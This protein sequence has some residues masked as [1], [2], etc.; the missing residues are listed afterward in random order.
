MLF[1]RYKNKKVSILGD[2]ISTLEGYNPAGSSIY[3]DAMMAKD[4]YVEKYSDTWWGML[5]EY[6]GAR[7]LINDSYSGSTM[8]AAYNILTYPAGCSLERIKNLGTEDEKPDLVIIFMG[9][10]DYYNKIPIY[11][12]NIENLRFFDNSYRFAIEMINRYYNKPEIWIL[13]IPSTINI[14]DKNYTFPESFDNT[15]LREY[16]K[17]L[18]EIAKDYNLKYIDLY[19]TGSYETL[20]G[21]HPN[22]QGMVDI[23]E[24]IRAGI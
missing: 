13:N 19:K 7:L 2:S 15:Y 8:A 17:A 20:D 14:K 5:I 4:T 9:T 11:N 12:E 24:M 10:N 16:N 18:L 23:F 1:N 3:Y 6:L 22:K 21:V